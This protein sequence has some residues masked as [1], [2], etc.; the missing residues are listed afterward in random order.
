MEKSDKGLLKIAAQA[1]G[2]KNFQSALL[3]K[4]ALIADYD[5]SLA[6]DGK[7]VLTRLKKIFC[8]YLKI[9]SIEECRLAF[10]D[11]FPGIEDTITVYA[12]AS[13]LLPEEEIEDYNSENKSFLDFK[14][15]LAS[16]IYDK[17]ANDYELAKQEI[18]SLKKQLEL[19]I[20]KTGARYKYEQ[21]VSYIDDYNNFI[22]SRDMLLGLDKAASEQIEIRQL[23]KEKVEKEIRELQIQVE[24][25]QKKKNIIWL[26]LKK[27][28]ENSQQKIK[29]LEKMLAT[30]DRRDAKDKEAS[31]NAQNGIITLEKNFLL[32]VGKGYTLEEYENIINGD[33]PK[34]DLTNLE[35]Q[36]QEVL[37]KIN[38]TDLKTKEEDFNVAKMLYGNYIKH[39]KS[40]KSH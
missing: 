12:N 29:D 1:Y 35:K 34:E 33:Y 37:N 25:M 2:G 36:Y 9:S 6:K 21:A 23:K 40:N 32:T 4:E 19:L 20:E 18:T 3:A 5:A 39:K 24:Q 14:A 31:V 26:L 15:Y 16:K 13:Q 38:S 7:E 10:N 22:N 30:Y 8:I 27:K 28:N 11:I 17:R